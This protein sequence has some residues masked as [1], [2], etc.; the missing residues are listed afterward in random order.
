MKE[1]VKAI[2]PVFIFLFL[3]LMLHKSPIKYVNAFSEGV[4]RTSGILLQFPFYA[5]IMGIMTDSGLASVI[6][7]FFINIANTTTLPL[8]NFLASGILNFFVPSGG[9]KWAIE[10]F[11][12][13]ETA[14]QLKADLP[15]VITAVAWGDAWTNMAQPFWALPLLSVANLDVKD[16]LGYTTLTMLI[17]GIMYL[18]IFLIF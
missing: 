18:S 9:G 7:Q 11:F 3:G 17:T 1:L 2:Y 12:V 5:G 15:K 13:I 16:I 4:K 14:V 8:F 6:T 10:S